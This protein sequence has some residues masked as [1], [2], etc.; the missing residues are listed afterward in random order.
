MKPNFKHGLMALG[1]GSLAYF[2]NKKHK[3]VLAQE[4][5]Y[6]GRMCPPDKIGL[7]GTAKVP[8]ACAPP[9]PLVL[10]LKQVQVM[11]RHGARTPLHT[12]TKF[13]E[14][15]FDPNFVSREHQSTIFPF[16]KVGSNNSKPVPWSEYEQR[17]MKKKLRG[18]ACYGSLTSYGKEQMYIL[19]IN[20]RNCYRN[21]LGL[22]T[23]NP[24]HVSVLSSNIMRT[25]ES[26][27]CVLAGFFGKEQLASFAE[28]RNP[29]D[30]HIADEN[31]NI[32]VPDTNVCEVL[33][34]VN[35][36]A[37]LHSDFIEQMKDDRLK[38]EAEIDRGIEVKMETLKTAQRLLSNQVSHENISFIPET[39]LK[40]NKPSPFNEPKTYPLLQDRNKAAEDIHRFWSRVIMRH[41]VLRENI[42]E[43]DLKMLF[44]L[45]RLEVEKLENEFYS[46]YKFHFYFDPK[47]PFFYNQHLI[48][49]IYTRV[50]PI[51]NL[52]K[53]TPILWKDFEVPCKEEKKEK[54]KCGSCGKKERKNK[55]AFLKKNEKY[56]SCKK[57]TIKKQM[58]FFEWYSKPITAE[59]DCFGKILMDEIYV[60]P[61][62][63]LEE[64][65]KL[66]DPWEHK[67]NFVLARDDVIS[68][69]AHG[70]MYPP[71]IERFD[72]IINRNAIKLMHYAMTGQHEKERCFITRLSGGP[73]FTEIVDQLEKRIK[74]DKCSKLILYS[75]HDSTMTAMLEIL[76]IWDDKWPPFAADLRFELYKAT[77]CNEWY[78]RVLYLGKVCQ[79]GGEDQDYV[80]WR[81]F[82]KAL[83]RYLIRQDEF[84][85]LCSS[86]ILE[87][88]AKEILQHEEKETYTPEV[89]EESETPAGM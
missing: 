82:K 12:L 45:K 44:Y 3:Y 78:V 72:S 60:N 18:G 86:Q 32:L 4:A 71:G 64:T 2:Y 27:R 74:G 5:D 89:K 49:E 13:E 76:N 54:P 63:Y 68:R 43:E 33:K 35:H 75:S 34:K 38:V 14:A 48:K 6:E 61:L 73:L 65:P 39:H 62:V 17:L 67:L 59:E 85:K 77:N 81:D 36:S 56:C 23:Y 58:S 53:Q 9:G 10:E 21:R 50:N 84:K 70:W 8:K 79:I 46:G 30:I 15:A 42:S 19:G 37:M 40:Y 69:K 24:C 20:L 41:P 51:A 16:Q 52:S 22:C 29:I 47:N 87:K 1:G 7:H 11:F 31:Y 25:V 66:K 28:N 88:I 83:C 57:E 80:S 26:A 55:C